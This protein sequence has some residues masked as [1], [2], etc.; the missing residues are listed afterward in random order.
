MIRRGAAGRIASMRRSI[1]AVL[2]FQSDPA[3]DPN[4]GDGQIVTRL[5]RAE[6]TLQGLVLQRAEHLRALTTASQA[7]VASNINARMTP[8]IDKGKTA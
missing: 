4:Q 8:L 3:R 2:S 7:V 1:T 6:R 5:V